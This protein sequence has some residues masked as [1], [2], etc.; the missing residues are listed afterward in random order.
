[1]G[2]SAGQYSQGQYCTAIGTLAGNITQNDYSVAVGYEAGYL[3]QGNSCI[4]IGQNAGHDNQALN[5][6]ALGTRAGR[7]TQSQNS[8]GIG[9][10][11]GAITQGENSISLGNSAGYTNQGNGSL[12]ICQGAGYAQQGSDS[13]AIGYNAG[14]FYQST[15][16]IAIGVNAGY[17]NQGYNSIAIGIGNVDTDI[18]PESIAIGSCGSLYYTAI[19][20]IALNPST[21]NYNLIHH[22]N[23]IVLNASTTDS[24][25]TTGEG[26][27]I[28]PIRYQN[29]GYTGVLYNNTTTNEVVCGPAG[30]F[31]SNFQSTQNN[32]SFTGSNGLV[33]INFSNSFFQSG[34]GSFRF[35]SPSPEYDDI[36][37]LPYNYMIMG[38]LCFLSI[39][40]NGANWG[41]SNQPSDVGYLYTKILTGSPLLPKNLT[42][43][44]IPVIIPLYPLIA[45]TLQDD[46]TT[47]L[48]A[49]V[50]LFCLRYDSY[51]GSNV[52]SLSLYQNNSQLG[53]Q[54]CVIQSPNGSKINILSVAFSQSSGTLFFQSATFTYNLLSF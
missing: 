8:I 28:N 6:I 53:L 19:N 41:N 11:A 36:M 46:G 24:I 37:I 14:H 35:G 54:P 21:Q 2:N 42:M 25:A 10:D 48:G 39:D 18:P 22:P 5:S 29:T 43:G 50:G 13:I 51:I 4:A 16:C 12:A 20:S 44:Q 23:T 52:I 34:A 17:T 1:M 40:L 15:G 47:N 31:P 45:V 7:D 30:P 33:D 26:L 49:Y 38:G 3:N 9:Q 27:Y 32:L